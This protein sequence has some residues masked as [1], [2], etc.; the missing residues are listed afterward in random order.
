MNILL[1]D[2]NIKNV[3]KSLIISNLVCDS[4]SDVVADDSGSINYGLDSIAGGSRDV[5]SDLLCMKQT[6]NR[7]LFTFQLV[8]K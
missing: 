8:H 7:I 6:I 5:A 4:I 3:H 1:S 2:L